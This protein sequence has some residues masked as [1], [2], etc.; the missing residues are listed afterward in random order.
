MIIIINTKN[1]IVQFKAN[2]TRTEK[3]IPIALFGTGQFVKDS[4]DGSVILI[5]GFKGF[6]DVAVFL[7]DYK[8]GSLTEHFRPVQDAIRSIPGY[9]DYILSVNIT[10]EDYRFFVDELGK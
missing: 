7:K 3:W 10:L 1:G 4:K 2:Y 9:E 6:L 8:N 5:I